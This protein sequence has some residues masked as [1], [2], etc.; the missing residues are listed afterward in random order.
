MTDAKFSNLNV[1]FPQLLRA[2]SILSSLKHTSEVLFYKRHKIKRMHAEEMRV[3]MR[4]I[5]VKCVGKNVVIQE[6]KLFA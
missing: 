5:S 4:I 6:D 3:G 1:A 2:N